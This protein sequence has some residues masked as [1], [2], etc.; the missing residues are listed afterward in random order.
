[1]PRGKGIQVVKIFLQLMRPAEVEL[2]TSSTRL[3]YLQSRIP[4]AQVD[5]RGTTPT[6]ML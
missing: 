6:L 3:R 2:A 5:F 1:M 4:R